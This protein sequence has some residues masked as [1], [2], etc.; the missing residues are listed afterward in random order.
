MSAR[1]PKYSDEEFARRGQEI[2]ESQVREKVEANNHGQIV[3]IDIET[4][5]YEIADRSVLAAKQLLK[6][7]PD[8]QIYGIRVGYPVVHRFGFHS[9][10]TSQ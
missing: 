8:A 2:Y 6:R 7:N 4:G 1:K 10:K 5:A 9:P 3:A